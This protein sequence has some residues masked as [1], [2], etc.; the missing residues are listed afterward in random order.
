MQE[1]ATVAYVVVFS[2]I[3][4]RVTNSWKKRKQFR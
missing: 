3:D 2:T 4:A 1:N